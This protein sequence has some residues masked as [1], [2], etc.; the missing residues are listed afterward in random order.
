MVVLCQCDS[1][2]KQPSG[3]PLLFICDF[4]SRTKVRLLLS[5]LVILTFVSAFTIS[6]ASRGVS[7]ASGPAAITYKGVAS[8]VTRSAASKFVLRSTASPGVG[9][10]RVTPVF[11]KQSASNATSA[12]GKNAP[13]VADSGGGNSAGNLLRNFNGLN[14]VD[15]FNVNGFILEP[16][17]QGLCVGNL[18]GSK[19]TS[20]IINDVVAFYKPNGTLF[21]P[22]ENLNV[23]F[24]EPATLNTSDPR[25][26]YDP[27]TQSWFFSIVVYTNTLIP[28]HT[29]VLVLQPNLLTA[30]Y[31]IDTTLPNNTAG[32][33]PCFGD[34]PKL[35]IDKNNVYISVD[36][37][38]GPGLALE[39]GRSV[40]S[41]EVTAC[42]R[43]I[44]RQ[45]SRVSQPFLGG[46]WDHCFAACDN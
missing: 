1:R 39:T 46:N 33:C 7:R 24:G 6:F 28:N 29:D 36:Q 9:R 17:D 15:S 25:C 41:L 13:N 10:I 45:H 5:L 23:F 20:E 35:G 12:V 18:L 31:Q 40:R 2:Q 32:G 26:L 4:T 38:G 30:V 16:P 34:Q 44:H 14:S 22:L 11:H 27:T 19:V 3:A 42:G 8:T 37:F 43:R 21:G